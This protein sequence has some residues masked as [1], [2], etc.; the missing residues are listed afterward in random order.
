MAV[1]RP[2]YVRRTPENVLERQIRAVVYYRLRALHYVRP[3]VLCATPP[4]PYV[5]VNFEYFAL[6]AA[7][8]TFVYYKTTARG[9]RRMP[10]K[11]IL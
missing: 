10:A 9:F 6:F 11:S 8:R 2:L 5:L 3:A 1:P 4:V 7:V